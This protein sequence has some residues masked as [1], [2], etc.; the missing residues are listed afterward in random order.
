ML[1]CFLLVSTEKYIAKV[2]RSFFFFHIYTSTDMMFVA[3]SSENGLFCLDT[4]DGMYFL[5]CLQAVKEKNTTIAENKQASSIDLP[6]N[7]LYHHHPQ[8]DDEISSQIQLTCF[9]PFSGCKSHFALA[10]AFILKK[11]KVS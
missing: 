5:F 10:D 1:M 8:S 7:V 4:R 2:T 11:K 9:T 3:T 6:Q